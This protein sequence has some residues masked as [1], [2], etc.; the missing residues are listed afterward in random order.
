MLHVVE[1]FAGIGAQA[2]ALERLG[3]PF[4][5]TVSE[6]DPHAYSIYCAIHGDAPNLGDITKVQH[7]PECDLL[8]YSPPCQDI[9]I[10]GNQKG[11]VEG[12]GT[13]SSLFWEVLR[14]LKDAK[15][16]GQLPPVLV[17]ENVDAIISKQ[18]RPHLERFIIALNE[19]GY[20]SSWTLLNSKDYG[21]PQNRNRF[22]MVSTLD[23]GTFIFPQAQPLEKRLKDVLEDDV[24]ESFY[25]SAETI[26]KYRKHKEIQKALGRGYGWDPQDP[27]RERESHTILTSPHKS[28]G[29]FI[30]VH[31][32]IEGQGEPGPRDIISGILVRDGFLE[33]NNRVH[34][35]EGIAPTILA[36]LGGV[37]LIEVEYDVNR[38]N[39]NKDTDAQGMFQTDGADR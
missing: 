14:L 31:P 32:K 39:Q 7:L 1:L 30:I 22:F 36:R 18:N 24:D 25:L 37:P 23:R 10:A 13:R 21:V 6:I 9:S 27:E 20:D 29:N 11:L 3:I 16:R 33:M 15:E 4:T 17:M 34:S 8:T 19:L 5:S 38:I 2:S 26:E 35:I 12:S 28:S